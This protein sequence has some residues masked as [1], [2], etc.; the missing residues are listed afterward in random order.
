MGY[1]IITKPG[2]PTLEDWQ[3]QL[4]NKRYT[5]GYAGRQAQFYMQRRNQGADVGE[6]GRF[7][8]I[9]AQAKAEQRSIKEN[10]G[11]GAN[12][13]IAQGGGE[14]ANI[15]QAQI[16]K[17]LNQS[18][19]NEGV[20]V[21]NAANEAYQNAQQVYNDALA[22]KQQLNQQNMI[23]GLGNRLGYYG[24]RYQVGQTSGFFDKL[25]QIGQFLGGAGAAKAAF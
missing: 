8:P 17:D 2:D 6:E 25:G 12:A 3:N 21:S 23:A 13:L 24:Q 22:R 20:N 4:F 10:A 18:R 16:N 5:L 11:Q 14:N 9:M 7:A 15:I 19:E 1:K